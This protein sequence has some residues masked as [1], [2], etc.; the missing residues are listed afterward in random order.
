MANV[1]N[2]TV[3]NTTTEWI[4]KQ[5]R[6]CY[7]VTPVRMDVRNKEDCNP[8]FSRDLKQ[9][10]GNNSCQ[11]TSSLQ[12]WPPALTLVTFIYNKLKIQVH[13]NNC[14]WLSDLT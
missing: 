1:F 13:G 4:S 6:K 7:P 12:T 11:G 14:Q 9:R 8:R 2:E 3:H 5:D 10:W